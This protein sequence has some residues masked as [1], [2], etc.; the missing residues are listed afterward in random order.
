MAE[1]PLKGK[2]G[3][4]TEGWESWRT[5]PGVHRNPPGLDPPPLF[6]PPPPL[7]PHRPAALQLS[8]GVATSSH[9]LSEETPRLHSSSA[10]APEFVSA[11]SPVLLAGGVSPP[12]TP[13]A[14]G[15]PGPTRSLWAF[16]LRELQWGH[17]LSWRQ[18]GS[19]TEHVMNFLR[20]TLAL[21]PFLTFGHLLCLDLFLFHFTILPLR[22]LG[23]LWGLGRLALGSLLPGSSSSS[24]AAPPASSRAAAG[25]GFTQAQAYDLIKAAIFVAATLALGA[26]QV[27]RVYH[28]IRGEAIIKLCVAWRQAGAGACLRAYAPPPS[29]RALTHPLSSPP[30]HCLPSLTLH[31]AM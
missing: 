12:S 9:D 4:L 27:S 14:Q 23:A 2:G 29:L 26:V 7:P 25:H 1:T 31:T 11:A 8:T 5:V 28:Y 6:S 18:R 15:S 21:E 24:V 20:V 10:L 22:C 16:F 17:T 13:L 30:L 19:P 3:G